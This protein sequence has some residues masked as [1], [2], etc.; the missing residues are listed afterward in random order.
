MALDETEAGQSNGS[1]TPTAA[2]SQH[3]AHEH[4]APGTVVGRYRIVERLAVGGMGVVFKALDPELSRHVALKLVQSSSIDVQPE[5][6]DEYEQRLL[7]EAQAL[8]RLS[9]PNVVAAF[10]VGRFANALFIA[11]ELIDGVS[12]RAW[13][14]GK[15]RTRPEILR[16]LLDA[17]RG[18]SAAHRAGV[19]HRDFKL[20]NVMVSEQ[21]RV[22]VVD[23]GLARTMGVV[24]ELEVKPGVSATEPDESSSNR[25]S[26][27]PTN[28]ELTR[29]GALIGTPGYIAPEQFE[30]GATDER[31]DQFSYASA[32]FLALT[33][34]SPHPVDSVAEYRAAVLGAERAPWPNSVPRAVRRVIDRGLSRRPDERY[35]S[36]DAL[37]T[38]LERAARP[39]RRLALLVL[40]AL[41]MSALVSTLSLRERWMQRCEPDQGAFERVWSSERRARIEG[42]FRGSGSARAGDNITAVTSGVA[43]FRE[44]WQDARQEACSATYERHEQSEQIL[45]LRNACL[46]SKL[47]QFATLAELFERADAALVDRAPDALAELTRVG[48][49]SNIL[50]LVGGGDRLPDDRE[51]REP[52]EALLR[53]WDTLQA[54]YVTGRW[55][56]VLEQG[57][58]LVRDAEQVGY[59]PMRARGMS[60]VSI[61]LD[62]LGRP[63][64]A[65]ALR[66]R[67]LAVAAEAK[68]HDVLAE[69]ALRQ[70]RSAVDALRLVEAKA[71]LPFVDVAV[72]LAGRASD[73]QVRLL[74]YEAAILTEERD[75]SAAIDRLEQA[76]AECRQLGAEALRSCLPP[77]REL[78][79]VYGARKDLAAARREFEATIQLAKQALG[80]RHPNVV[81]EYNN[82]AIIMLRLRDTETATRFITE[83]KLLA[84]GLPPDRQSA[85]IP[86]I[87]GDI[88][89]VRGDCRAAIPFFEESARRM[90][91]VYGERSSQAS[92]GPHDLGECL[93]RLG[94]SAAAIPHLEHA[95]ELRRE[96]R[97]KPDWIARSAFLLAEA[98]WGMPAER[99]R[100]RQLAEE[101]LAIY[102]NAGENLAEES[103]RVSA[104]L[105]AR[106]ATR[107]Q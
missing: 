97:V 45:S 79:V 7:R 21:G 67:T 44:R 48:E 85:K 2:G 24:L 47:R 35:P 81:N 42:A 51:R 104:W 57:Q 11:M 80:P 66:K 53:R 10:D 73:Q 86:Q 98:L 76:L 102:Q 20:S 64:E 55:S 30:G 40:T 17:G 16:V 34:R 46:D 19:I 75:F 69:Q 58:A 100:A 13:L 59:S 18:L 14:L 25:L 105:E 71:M 88:L 82:G 52:I 39:P 37:L 32:A 38:D 22:L 96:N 87:Q 4:L 12:L 99:A 61:A 56:E 5:R 72:G 74:T 60:H 50:N 68:V 31:S 26:S 77:Q 62:R 54:T 41:A 106:P 107:R 89:S 101:A 78:G 9:H 70:L 3:L 63:D 28:G 36:L 8:A 1:F 6:A 65:V 43:G 93:V 83:S 23:F 91:A 92:D 90:A 103:Q 49:C 29:T 94:E 27:S 84:A 33:G 15:Q 95:L